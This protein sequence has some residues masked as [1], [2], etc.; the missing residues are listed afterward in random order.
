MRVGLTCIAQK[1]KGSSDIRK[2]GTEE[3]HLSEPIILLPPR[4]SSKCRFASIIGTLGNGATDDYCFLAKRA[5]ED[6]A[7]DHSPCEDEPWLRTIDFSHKAAVMQVSAVLRRL[8]LIDPECLVVGNPPQEGNE[9][10][11]IQHAFVDATRKVGNWIAQ[12]PSQERWY[13]EIW[14]L[15]T[16]FTLL[17]P[18]EG[19]QADGN[20]GG[21]QDSD[22]LFTPFRKEVYG[23]YDHIFWDVYHTLKD[24]T[25]D[26]IGEFKPPNTTIM[27]LR[28]SMDETP[29]IDH[30]FTTDTFVYPVWIAPKTTLTFSVDG[31][32]STL[33]PE[34]HTWRS[35]LWF[36][37]GKIVTM[38]SKDEAGERSGR[39]FAVLALG[40]CEARLLPHIAL[41]DHTIGPHRMGLSDAK[42]WA[43]SSDEGGEN[44]PESWPE[45][46][47]LARA[48]FLKAG[49]AVDQCSFD[50]VY[51][52]VEEEQP[53]HQLANCT[54]GIQLD[55][56]PLYSPLIGNSSIRILIIAPGSAEEDLRTR[57]VAVELDDKPAYEA[58]SYT[59]GDPSDKT[60]L[61]CNNTEVPIPWNLEKALRRLRH[62]S[63][64]RSVWAD[65]VCINQQD[66]PERGQQV[67]IMRNIYQNAER[68]LVWLGLDQHDQASTAFTAIC[69]IVRAWRPKGDRVGFP[70]YASLLEPMD[71]NELASVRAAVGQEAWEALRALFETNYFRRFWIIQELALGGSAVVLWGD[72][73][74]SWGLVGICAAWI[75]TSG[76]NFNYGAPLTAAYNAFLI[77]VLPLANRSGISAFS[78]LDL[79][80]VLG[81]TMGRFD[82]TDARDRIYALL[83]MSFAGNNPDH[84]LLLQP[85]YTKDLRS[86]YTQAA[87][88]IL[89]QD[90]HLRMLSAVQHTADG[91]DLS[92]PSW[93]PKWDQPFYAEP[94]ALRDEQGYYAN[95]GELFCPSAETFDS[96]G[97]SLKLSGLLCS[98]ITEVSEE[99][100]K[101]NL[102]FQA[103]GKDSH[104]EAMMAIFGQLNDESRQLRASWSA[105]LEKFTLF[106][107][108]DPEFQAKQ[109]TN[110]KALSVAVTSQPGKYGMRE[111]VEHLR[112]ERSQNDHL[113]E[114][115]LYWRERVSWQMAELQHK[116]M[117]LFWKT[118]EQ[119]GT[120]YMKE[121]ALCAINSMAGRRIFLSD[122]GKAGLGPVVTRPGDVIAILFGSIVPFVLRPFDGP[123]GR[124]CWK[125]VGECF[126]PGLMQG[127][128]VEQAG[129][130]AKGTF[131]RYKDGSLTLIPREQDETDPR[132]DRKVGEH[133][134]CSFEIR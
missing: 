37:A 2:W 53:E 86:V 95:G 76:W 91:I 124:K 64:P 117:D 103:I 24:E 84:R 132:L 8:W 79:S 20:D 17:D 22:P 111:S 128:A 99:L 16:D 109:V 43:N 28:A 14:R 122:D 6:M 87:R 131:D 51:V 127:E 30:L 115:L 93:V 106:G 110:D 96:N 66:I 120:V 100:Q 98:T 3:G 65:S 80:V 7:M 74:I 78:K 33:L 18:P 101:G 47:H 61:A 113:G 12:T 105:T 9:A 82:S 114:F 90:K 26:D 85:D 42:P 31:S 72:H 130:L 118:V 94:L 68:V 77:Y 83:G 10:T 126:V 104:R 27:V 75:M 29:E 134:V 44:T 108:S 48:I 58:I 13:D 70:G 57:L 49:D 107:F 1:F 81:T 59:W 54:S 34:G 133:G 69:S 4:S 62:S 89:E 40:Q 116:S 97:N 45:A 19:S 35:S 5:F 46:D 21:D 92:Y 15:Q 63:R 32:E 112:G 60:V 129:L 25:E 102:R 36:R 38:T 73:H 67:S 23:V 41:K 119:H 121:R 50:D 55:D 123:E 11:P 88:C 125:L 56:S 39:I 71:D 52:R